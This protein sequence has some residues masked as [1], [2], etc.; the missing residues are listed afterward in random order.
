[1][2]GVPGAPVPV[3]FADVTA[4]FGPEWQLAEDHFCWTATRRPTQTAVEI[5]V[6]QDLDHLAAKLRAERD[7]Q[8]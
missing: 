4:E 3:T 5:I 1:M 7:D 6:G 8:G 2:T